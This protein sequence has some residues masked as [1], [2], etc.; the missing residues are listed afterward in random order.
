MRIYDYECDEKG[1]IGDMFIAT[2][3][4]HGIEGI[5]EDRSVGIPLGCELCRRE[6]TWVKVKDYFHA[7]SGGLL[8]GKGGGKL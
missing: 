2:C 8:E 6:V 4:K 3:E 5:I 1:N 7:K